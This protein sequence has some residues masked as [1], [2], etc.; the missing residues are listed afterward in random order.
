MR[1]PGNGIAVDGDFDPT[2]S[3]GRRSLAGCSIPSWAAACSRRL[4]SRR[5]DGRSPRLRPQPVAI[6]VWSWRSPASTPCLS[7]MFASSN[8][9]SGP[10][11][12]LP[13][14]W[15][16][17]P[18]VPCEL[19]GSV[20]SCGLAASIASTGSRSWS[21]SRS[22]PCSRGGARGGEPSL[23]T[24]TAGGHAVQES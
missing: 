14:V 18:A 2:G 4:S 11:F 10:C 8:W 9:K 7:G 21:R 20:L 22:L 12:G 5:W 19:A 13:T 6:E 17:A 1:R 15:Y 3:S 16:F 24:V 23:E